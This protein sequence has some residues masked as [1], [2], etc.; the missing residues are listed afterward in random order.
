MGLFLCPD[1]TV[2]ILT[3][4]SPSVPSFYQKPRRIMRLFCC[5]QF[6]KL[7]LVIDYV[8]GDC[9]RCTT[10][11]HFVL[12]QWPE[13]KPS[14]RF[15]IIIEDRS[16]TCVLHVKRKSLDAGACVIRLKGTILF[17]RPK[18][19]R[20]FPV[21]NNSFNACRCGLAVR[22]CNMTAINLKRTISG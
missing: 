11:V 19:G 16:A 7:A 14:R 4:T 17:E 8:V 6:C 1:A 20:I 22:N 9:K 10:Y 15:S 18:C 5:P 2:R 13:G 21:Y 3:E 12:P